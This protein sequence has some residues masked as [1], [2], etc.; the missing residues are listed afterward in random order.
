MNRRQKNWSWTWKSCCLY[1]RAWK[2]GKIRFYP[3]KSTSN[4]LAK[5]S[6]KVFWSRA[7]SPSSVI[8][9]VVT[10]I[11]T[12]HN[13]HHKAIVAVMCLY[14]L[15]SIQTIYPSKQHASNNTHH[16]DIRGLDD[17]NDFLDMQVT[18]QTN[19]GGVRNNGARAGERGWIG[20]IVRKSSGVNSILFPI[21]LLCIDCWW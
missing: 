8:A 13:C 1:S 16:Q 3:P 7:L 6:D 9:A 21:L 19:G 4:T 12:H 10:A 18:Y 20:V 17:Q 11:G 2:A 14:I 5:K 15:I